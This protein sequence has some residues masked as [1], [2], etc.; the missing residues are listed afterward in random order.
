MQGPVQYLCNNITAFLTVRCCTERSSTVVCMIYS[1]RFTLKWLYCE[2]ITTN[3]FN[4]R[5][6]LHRP[7]ILLKMGYNGLTYFC[8]TLPLLFSKLSQG[9]W[10]V[11]RFMATITMWG[12]WFRSTVV[13]VWHLIS[14]GPPVAMRPTGGASEVRKLVKNL[15]D[16][17]NFF[18]QSAASPFESPDISLADRRSGRQRSVVGSTKFAINNG[19]CIQ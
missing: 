18:N 5:H 9:D 19:C 15:H 17:S 14:G 10:K 11:T 12:E 13:S 7:D 1:I 2:L 4:N 3:R 6:L 16:G 8:L